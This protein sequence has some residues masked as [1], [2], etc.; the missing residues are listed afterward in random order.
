MG[1]VAEA[2]HASQSTQTSVSAK[3]LGEARLQTKR[4]V[5]L[6]CEKPLPIFQQTIDHLKKFQNKPNTS[7]PKIVE[8][9]RLDPGYSLQVF[10]SANTILT[11]NNRET[12]SSLNHA[13]LLLGIPKLFA[14]GKELPLLSELQNQQAKGQIYQIITRSYHSGVQAREWMS[15]HGRSSADTAFFSAQLRDMYLVGLWFH[16]SNEI[17]SLM[18]SSPLQSLFAPNGLLT[19]I[20]EQLAHH[21]CLPTFLQQSFNPPNDAGRLVQTIAFANQVSQLA[22]YGWYTKQMDN[23][24]EQSSMILG[25]PQNLITQQIH[26][27]AVTA[28]RESK[29]YPIR[30]AAYRLVELKSLEKPEVRSTRPVK[31]QVKKTAIKQPVVKRVEEP[32]F[33]QQVQKL[34]TMG[35]K[36]R[37]PQEILEYSF[38]LIDQ[39]SEGRPIAFFLLDKNRKVLKSRFI[40]NFV[41]QKK[42]ISLSLVK[43]GIFKPLMQ[44]QQSV[45]INPTSR[46]KFATLLTTEL[47]I[48]VHEKDFFAISLFIQE[49]PVGLFYFEGD[50]SKP[51]SADLY[52]KFVSIC[53]TAGTSLDEVKKHAQ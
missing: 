52:K 19:T 35:E 17:S 3:T 24:I 45:W 25:V 46:K 51:L 43:K 10:R 34:V 30:P 22:E 42:N 49:K 11:K 16:A 33:N 31:K 20:G 18:K 5:D 23:F 2:V 13:I 27:N 9:L 39:I 1:A 41:D 15:D 47:P 32:G 38:K 44:K 29:F 53:T 36:R 14:I 48:K 37:P 40:K 4:L 26:S 7:I 6:V 50:P 12:A 8:I 21:W 28:A